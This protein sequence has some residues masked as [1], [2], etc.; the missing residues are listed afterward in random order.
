MQNL[1]ILFKMRLLLAI[2]LYI[3]LWIYKFEDWK[4]LELEM[5]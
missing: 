4:F 3:I 5:Y 2:K 1:L